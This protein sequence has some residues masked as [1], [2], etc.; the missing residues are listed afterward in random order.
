MNQNKIGHDGQSSR[1]L[2]NSVFETAFV[3]RI[4]ATLDLLLEP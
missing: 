1:G 3:L 2:Q 4:D